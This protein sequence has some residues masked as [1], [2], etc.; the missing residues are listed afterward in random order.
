MMIRAVVL[1]A[2]GC[3]VLSLLS[4]P[5][6]AGRRAL[7]IG[8]LAALLIIFSVLDALASIFRAARDY[9]D[10]AAIH[11]LDQPVEPP[12]KTGN[13]RYELKVSA[14]RWVYATLP[15]IAPEKLITLA[16]GILRGVPFS[17]RAWRGSIGNFRS[18]QDEFERRGLAR[19]RGRSPQQG[20]K[21]TRDGL[22]AMRDIHNGRAP[23]QI[24]PSPT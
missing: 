12:D 4:D 8:I 22:E 15:N 23:R 17:E 19:M 11:K 10:S 18:I 6:V 16:D 21:L 1:A 5:A 20:Y 2:L 24:S 9:M 3:W 14:Q 13:A 7:A